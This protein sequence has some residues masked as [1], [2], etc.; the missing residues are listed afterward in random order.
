L[1]KLK[2]KWVGEGKEKKKQRRFLEDQKK[3][4]EK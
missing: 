2:K 1:R 4:K 3:E